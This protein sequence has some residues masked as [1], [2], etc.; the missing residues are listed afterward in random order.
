M[1][2]IFL[3]LKTDHV[4]TETISNSDSNSLSIW[5][6][7][8]LAELIII[9]FLI[10]TIK[11]KQKSLKFADLS[12]DKIRNAKKSDIDMDNLMNSINSSK[13]LYKELSRTCHPDRFINS[14]KQN[15]AE[16]IFQEISKNKRD[17]KNLTEL[18]QRAITELNINL[19]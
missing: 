7:I 3:Q 2:N 17:F 1:R 11:K 5:F 8:A 14:D 9:A 13:D 4:V 19:K 15:I 18:K 6:W 16:E 12:K 10:I